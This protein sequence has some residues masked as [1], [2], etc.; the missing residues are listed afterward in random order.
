MLQRRTL[1]GTAALL[2]GLMSAPRA[3]AAPADLQQS[4]LI[5]KLEG[6]TVLLDP[7][8]RP[9]AFHEAPMLA[10]RVKA[11]HLPP[12]E[13]RLP[14]EPLV[15]KPLHEIGRYGGTWRR[16][17]IGPGD[18]ENGN[19]INAT[20][21]LIFWDYTASHMV[22]C[23]AK[24]WEVSEDGHTTKLFL[25][26]GM[27]WSDG[28]PFTADDFV[29]WFEDIYHNSDLVPA[30]IGDMSIGGHPGRITKI[31]DT[32]I[33][34]EFD[35]P[36]FLFLEILAGD[37]LIGG[38]QSARQSDGL[39][40]G[41]YAPAHYLRQFLPKYSSLDTVTAL[42]KAAGFQ[43]WV[44][45]FHARSDWRLNK[46]LPTLGPWHM[47][48][49]INGPVWLLERN[50]YYYAVDPDGN[51]LPYIDRVQLN[52]VESPDAVNLRAI[53]GEFDYQERFLDLSKLPVL[54]DNQERGNYK[55]HL[56]LGRCG[57][58]SNLM[59]NLTF[60]GDPEIAKWLRNVDFRRAL[61]LGVDRDQLNETF[62][63]GLGA[64][65]SSMPADSVPESP[66][67]EW[68]TKWSIFDPARANA[69]LDTIGLT[70]KGTDGLRLRTDRPE[71]LRI[72]ILVAQTLFPTWPQQAEMVAEQ[73]RKIGIATDV[74]VVERS[75]A[76]I[77]TRTDQDQIFLWDN[78]GTENLYLYA[79][80]VLPVD[81]TGGMYSDAYAQ[82]F[83]SNGAR[84]TAPDDPQLLKAYELLR[85]AG[86][87]RAEERN[88]IAKSIWR[89]A[90]DQ[91]YA[92]GIVGQSPADMG[93]R[94]VNNRLRNVPDRIPIDQ[95]C[96]NPGGAR[97]EQ[98][99]FAT[100]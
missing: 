46:D 45:A 56:D 7:A 16:A 82:W 95:I 49:P 23:V 71:T 85:S 30:P 67:G 65:G 62:W 96:R 89:I 42:A 91:Q 57:A 37:T 73:W 50:P 39:C 12:V 22:P 29:F 47:V 61:A 79:R 66:G 60:K 25:R 51:Q 48:Q 78:M 5:G 32:T 93:V 24:G 83:A 35:A 43:G 31:D 17:F 77:R 86:G 33:A 11:G 38:G 63:L 98:W 74:K 68:R 88:E 52:L 9:H 6:A 92:I 41:A 87:K 69:M 84:G 34:F 64:I 15:L 1:L 19:R 36:Y 53:A 13:Q 100:T 10:D 90:V 55:I 72:E 28:S 40:Y 70:K 81:P 97:P 75:L 18:S 2:P 3:I 80:Y 54:L 14:Q 94:L 4:G 59:F 21:K 44:D 99:Y 26:P 20:D 76:L 58:D 8:A 27:K